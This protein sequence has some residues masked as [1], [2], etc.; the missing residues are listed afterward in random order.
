MEV[1]PAVSA[2]G[3]VLESTKASPERDFPGLGGAG[4]G[5][6]EGH[7]GL[8]CSITPFGG[9]SL[10]SCRAG[11]GARSPCESPAHHRRT[12]PSYAGPISSFQEAV[13]AEAAKL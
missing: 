5:A 4:K 1:A 2:P 12:H 9:V 6:S 10:A 8:L 3:K 11:A 13:A 7:W